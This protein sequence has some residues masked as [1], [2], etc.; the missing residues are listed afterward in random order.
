MCTR[1][2]LKITFYTVYTFIHTSYRATNKSY[3]CIKYVFILT[4]VD[5]HQVVKWVGGPTTF[6][7]SSS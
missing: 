3:M 5:F 6:S 7:I 1:K 2:S 4:I